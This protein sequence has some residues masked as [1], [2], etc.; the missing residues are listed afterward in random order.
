[1]TAESDCPT[2]RFARRNR[3]FYAKQIVESGGKD[4]GYDFYP[5]DSYQET[6]QLLFDGF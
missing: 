1:L 2:F 4:V 3:R 6:N 5:F